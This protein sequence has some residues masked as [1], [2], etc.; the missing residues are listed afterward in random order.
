[1]WVV[2]PPVRVEGD[3]HVELAEDL[4]HDGYHH[5]SNLDASQQAIDLM[6]ARTSKLGLKWKVGNASNMSVFS[7]ASF[8][9]I[10]DKATLDSVLCGDESTKEAIGMLTECSRLLK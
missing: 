3:V 6:K 10:F 2:G 8:D 4:F 5:V 9:I 1:M 7:S